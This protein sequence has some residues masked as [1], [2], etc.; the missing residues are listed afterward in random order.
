MLLDGFA[1]HR[2]NKL[3][4]AAALSALLASRKGRR[5]AVFCFARSSA[6][7]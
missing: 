5:Q 7:A 6:A 4:S 1:R 2:V 3:A